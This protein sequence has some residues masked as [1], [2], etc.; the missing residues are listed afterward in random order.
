[1]GRL[2]NNIKR[3]FTIIPNEILYD[4]SICNNSKVVF[5]YMA[6][7]P[8]DWDF[9][10]ET[11]SSELHVSVDSVRKYLN[12]LCDSGW[13]T[14]IGQVVENGRFKNVEYILN[15]SPTS[16]QPDI[17][18]ET[19]GENFRHGKKPTRKI[20]DTENFGNILNKDIITKKEEEEINNI[21]ILPVNDK[22]ENWRTNY[23]LYVSVVNDAKDRLIDD[24]EYKLKMETWY[25]ATL[26]YKSTVLKTADWWLTEDGWMYSKKKKRGSAD[27]LSTLKRNLERNRIYTIGATKPFGQKASM[28]D[29]LEAFRKAR[30]L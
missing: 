28:D 30:G 26:D 14:K 9:F 11:I 20:S 22:S 16:E 3:N 21:N 24:I 18:D 4:S 15:E 17:N 27:M 8:D 29:K 10:H 19:V 13:V 5:W 25:G 1:M 6:S 7:K 23:G 2:F 12:E